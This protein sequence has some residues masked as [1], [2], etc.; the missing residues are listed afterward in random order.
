MTGYSK[1]KRAEQ[2][3]GFRPKAVA[4]QEPSE[5]GYTCPVCQNKSRLPGGEPDPRLTWSEYNAF[6]WCETCDMDYPSC[7]CLG[8]E[9]STAIEVFLDSIEGAVKR[10][11][12]AI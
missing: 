2:L 8:N 3:M 10:V 9:I 5:I 6:I 7:L 12:K 11:R 4:L 1:N